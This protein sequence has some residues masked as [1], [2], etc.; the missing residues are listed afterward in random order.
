[1]EIPKHVAIIPDGNR[2]WAKKHGVSVAEGYDKGIRKIGDVLK[3]CREYEIRTLS[4]WGFSTD[5]AKRNPEE[6]QK[7]F[8]LFKKYLAEAMEENQKASAEEKKKY[9]V[10][11]RFLGRRSLFPPEIQDAMNKIEGLT[12]NNKNYTLNLLLGY[13]GH[14]EIVDAV[15]ALLREGKKE[16]DE[17]D[18]ENR[19][20][21]AG[22]EHPDLVIRT[23][24]EQRLSG[25]LPWQTVYSEL[26][27][28]KK[29]W[30]DFG[31]GDFEDALKTYGRRMRRFGK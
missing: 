24:G 20:Y 25:L 29:L 9:N 22:Q 1:M 18:I 10:R 31:K 2:R 12:K 4:M 15:N 7:L 5:N 27:F 14:E 16:V 26:H 23:S 19:L 6:I 21:T 3:W 30:Q 13:G 8:G 28:S 11:I 17:K